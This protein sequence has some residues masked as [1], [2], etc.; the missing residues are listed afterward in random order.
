MIFV[1]KTCKFFGYTS[2]SCVVHLDINEAFKIQKVHL[3][4]FLFQAKHM[5]QRYA[6]A[7]CYILTILDGTL[8]N[9]TVRNLFQCV[10]KDIR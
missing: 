3:I 1:V 4:S 2:P 5:K 9:E 8:L 6:Y 10:F 7:W